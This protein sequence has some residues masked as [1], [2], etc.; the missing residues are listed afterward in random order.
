MPSRLIWNP[1]SLSLSQYKFV[2]VGSEVAVD[3]GK[4]TKEKARKNV[5]PERKNQRTFHLCHR[6]SR[7]HQ[8]VD[9]DFKQEENQQKG[10][11]RIVGGR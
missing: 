4:L 3:G 5:D 9:L 1:S 10:G 11:L 7:G 6:G 8:S 2:E